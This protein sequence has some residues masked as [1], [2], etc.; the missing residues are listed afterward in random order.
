M[1]YTSGSLD[2]LRLRLTFV[3]R[4]DLIVPSGQRSNRIK[5]FEENH[6]H[7][8]ILGFSFEDKIM[9]TVFWLQG[10]GS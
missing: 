5:N 7:R 8:L 10:G 4:H 2:C 3:C 6:A 9:K 1:D